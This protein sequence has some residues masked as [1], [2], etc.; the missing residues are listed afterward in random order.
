MP[1]NSIELIGLRQIGGALD[2]LK[3]RAVDEGNKAMKTEA[4]Q[5]LQRAKALTPVSTGALRD[6]GTVIEKR[7]ASGTEFQISFGGDGMDYALAVHERTDTK[8]ETGQ[9]KYL[10][11][12]VKES[13]RGMTR[14]VAAR[15]AR[16][17]KSIT[18]G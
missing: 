13:S 8:H 5:A 16:V 12:A 14:R 7:S 2:R 1:K 17:L 9:A 6:S 15:L 11:T 4:E 3:L 10:E 18:R